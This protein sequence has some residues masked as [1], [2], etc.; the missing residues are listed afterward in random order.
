MIIGIV[1]LVLALACANTANL[2]L[3][4]ATARMSEMGTRLAL[5]ASTARLINQM[6]NE[7]LLLCL[8]AGGLGLVLSIWLTPVL[9]ALLDLPAELT[10]RPD[11]RVLLFTMGVALVCGIGAGL[12][13]ARHGAR[14]NVLGALR[15]QGTTNGA[16]AIPSRLRTTFVG[17]QAAVSVFLLV[18][19][20]LLARSAMRAT[21]GSVGFDVDRLLGVAISAAITKR[22]TRRARRRPQDVGRRAGLA[23]REA[24]VQLH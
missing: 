12:A 20:A 4:A 18:A 7:S 8:T 6:V 24:A 5:G 17:F 15:S 14:G 2:L 16:G 11:G 19:A 3:A 9:R 10:L 23:R 13:P 22:S 1:G 21:A